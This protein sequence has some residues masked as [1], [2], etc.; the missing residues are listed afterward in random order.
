MAMMQ[1]DIDLLIKRYGPERGTY[2]AVM[3]LAEEQRFIENAV[4]KMAA[5]FEKIT[6][7]VTMQNT[8]LDVAKDKIDAMGKHFDTD[9]RS[10]HALV[11]STKDE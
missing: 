1:R 4:K 7:V 9:P 10:T 2:H 11:R 5:A 6:T 8:V 3:R